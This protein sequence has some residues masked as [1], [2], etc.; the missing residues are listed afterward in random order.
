MVARDK[1]LRKLK[2]LNSDK[3]AEVDQVAAHALKMCAEAVS[4]PLAF[5]FD[6]SINESM[7]P[8]EWKHAMSGLFSFSATDGSRAD[9]L[10]TIFERI[11]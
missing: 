9:P 5:I 2:S 1:V 8:V 11:G 3:T 7:L 10:H 6:K 4:G